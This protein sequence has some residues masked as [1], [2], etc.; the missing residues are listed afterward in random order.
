MHGYKER[1][2]MPVIMSRLQS[3]PAVALLGARQVGKSTVAQRVKSRLFQP[4]TGGF[5]RH[6]ALRFETPFSF[7]SR[8]FE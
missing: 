1:R 6:R 4:A 7:L 2:I 5:T 3:N 8:Y